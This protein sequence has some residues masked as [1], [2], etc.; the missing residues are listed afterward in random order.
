MFPLTFEINDAEIEDEV[1][2][3]IAA[4]E[5]LHN[6]DVFS[7]TSGINKSAMKYEVDENT[8][9]ITKEQLEMLSEQE[10]RLRDTIALQSM[11]RNEQ[12]SQI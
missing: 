2:S 5:K 8:A 11:L 9:F 7:S 6:E 1:I 10:Q 12:N 4:E 3:S